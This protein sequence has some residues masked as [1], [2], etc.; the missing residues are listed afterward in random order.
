MSVL[1]DGGSVI[2]LWD[3]VL[4]GKEGGPEGP[5]QFRIPSSETRYLNIDTF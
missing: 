5:F 4:G 1:S 2:S 3:N